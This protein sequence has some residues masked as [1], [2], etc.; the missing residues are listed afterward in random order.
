MTEDERNTITG[1]VSKVAVSAIDGL[2]AQ[3]AILFLVLLN[4]FM[5]ALLYFGVSASGAR[6]DDHLLRVIESCL[7]KH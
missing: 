3:P 4:A 1:A 7:A 2:K 6:R 5:F